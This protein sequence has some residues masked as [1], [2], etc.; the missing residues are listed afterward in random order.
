M[1]TVAEKIKML[2]GTNTQ[3]GC[4]HLKANDKRGRESGFVNILDDMDVIIIKCSDGF[5][6]CE[7]TSF[8]VELRDI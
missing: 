6:C 3:I 4:F 8:S 2:Q 5:F 7:K 1:K